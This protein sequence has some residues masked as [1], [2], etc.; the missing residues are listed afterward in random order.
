MYS[1]KI[2]LFSKEFEN[3]QKLYLN[4]YMLSYNKWFLFLDDISKFR[5]L[6]Q[7]VTAIDWLRFYCIWNNTIVHSMQ[8]LLF[9]C[10]CQYQMCWSYIQKDNPYTYM[11]QTIL[12]SESFQLLPLTVAFILGT[13]LGSG[14]SVFT[15][16]LC[17]T[18]YLANI[19]IME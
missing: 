16:L 7:V 2:R 11:F 13:M 12:D 4:V 18:R 10:R 17:K 1:Y 15:I 6:S 9:F 19:T 8:L 5:K 14:F 3:Q